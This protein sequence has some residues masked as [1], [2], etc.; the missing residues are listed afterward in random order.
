MVPTLRHVLVIGVDG[1]RFDLLGPAG[2][3]GC[4]ARSGRARPPLVLAA[5]G[6]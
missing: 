6:A 1:V 2:W 3:G 5:L 4:S